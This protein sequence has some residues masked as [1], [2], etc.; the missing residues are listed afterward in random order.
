MGVYGDPGIGEA[1]RKDVM[2]LGYNNVNFAY[3]PK[4]GKPVAGL[5][6]API[7]VNADGKLDAA[8][9]FYASRD[10]LL[11]AIADGRYPSPPARDL[12]LVTKGKPGKDVVKAFLAWALTEGQKYVSD[13]GYIV[14]PPERL[15][16]ELAKLATK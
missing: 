16:Q 1:V 8:E 13:T 6:P 11:A 2:G 5:A 15:K 10:Q 12:Y 14:L 9:N 4:T 3:D 7:D